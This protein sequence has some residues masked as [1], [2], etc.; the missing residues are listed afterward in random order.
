[1]LHVVYDASTTIN[2]YGINRT[3]QLLGALVSRLRVHIRE[4]Q[5][6]RE[7]EISPPTKH[8]QYLP[9]DECRVTPLRSRHRRSKKKLLV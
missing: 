4:P 1:M 8:L 6:R 7:V 5:Q 3:Q 9:S 2:C